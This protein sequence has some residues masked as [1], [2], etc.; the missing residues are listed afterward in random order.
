MW[1]KTTRLFL[2]DK[3]EIH[4]LS[5]YEVAAVILMIYPAFGSKKK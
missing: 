3:L 4:D 5:D 1:F 2:E